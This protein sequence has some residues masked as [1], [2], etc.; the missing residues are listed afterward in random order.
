MTT[1]QVLQP[2]TQDSFLD[3]CWICASPMG[4]DTQRVLESTK[5]SVTVDPER[6]Q[7]SRARS[8]SCAAETY[9]ERTRESATSRNNQ[10]GELDDDG[11]LTPNADDTSPTTIRLDALDRRVIEAIALGDSFTITSTELRAAR[12][13]NDEAR[14]RAK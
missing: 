1:P 8:S 12:E 13:W 10:D 6:T 2:G 9:G 5:V 11:L 14:M 4:S 7:S 3:E